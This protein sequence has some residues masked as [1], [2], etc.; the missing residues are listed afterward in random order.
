MPETGIFRL[1]FA[2]IFVTAITMSSIFRHRARRIGG[3]IPRAQEGRAALLARILFA[4]P[5]FLSIF[6]YMLNPAWMAW[7]S[8]DAPTWLRWTAAAVGVSMLPVLYWVLTSIGSNI[9]ETTLTKRDHALVTAGP[10]RWV[11]HP[12]YAA[13]TAAFAAMGVLAANWFI[14]TVS[15]LAL[16]LIRVVVIPKEEAELVRRFGDE[17]RRYAVRTG[18]LL[19]RLIRRS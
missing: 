11:R 16:A 10:Y 8:F 2:G 1:L 17:Y 9:S 6:A 19:P 3:V 7:S 5:L 18:A 4:A 15:V 14:T 13:S 12:L